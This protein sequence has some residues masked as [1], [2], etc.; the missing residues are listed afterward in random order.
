MFLGVLNLM[1][2]VIP[3]D[4]G[5]KVS[6]CIT[7]ALRFIVFL[8]IISSELTANSDSTP[9]LSKYIQIQIFMGG[10]ALVISPIQLRMH[11]KS[12]EQEGYTSLNISVKVAFCKSIKAKVSDTHKVNWS[13]T[14]M[15]LKSDFLE[16]G[17]ICH[18]FCDVLDS[19]FLFMHKHCY[20][21]SYF[22]ELIDI[23]VSSIS[24][25]SKI[26]S[27]YGGMKLFFIHMHYITKFGIR[28]YYWK[29][30]NL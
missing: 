9:Y 21:H 30:N 19:W 2:F 18:W 26:L 6:Y 5:K 25:S 8:T 7:V 17:F 22:K 20:H 24:I 28:F 10:I 13:R 1:V 27:L 15:N 23:F 12:E 11:H 4:T 29:K 3:A 16:R 14:R